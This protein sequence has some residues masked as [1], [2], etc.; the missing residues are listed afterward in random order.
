MKDPTTKGQ[1]AAQAAWKK[2][3]Y[4]RDVNGKFLMPLHPTHIDYRDYFWAN[5]HGNNT[6]VEVFDRAF[7]LEAVRLF[8]SGEIDNGTD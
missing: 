8:T 7:H 1:E 4:T 6:D 5:G 3:Q 2:Y